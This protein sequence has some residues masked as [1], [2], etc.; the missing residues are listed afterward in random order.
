MIFPNFQ[1]LP[2]SCSSYFNLS[3]KVYFGVYYKLDGKTHER[4]VRKFG[5]WVSME[6]EGRK[7]KKE[8]KR[9]RGGGAAHKMGEEEGF[10][11]L[12]LSLNFDFI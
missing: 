5:E 9:E 4:K 2:N 10:L 6:E 12:Y 3:I 11:F 7:R 8:R 1:F